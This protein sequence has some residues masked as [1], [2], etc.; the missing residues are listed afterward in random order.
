MPLRFT[1]TDLQEFDG[2]YLTRFAANIGDANAGYQLKFYKGAAGNN[3]IYSQILTDI[4]ANSWNTFEL[5]MPVEIDADHDLFIAIQVTNANNNIPTIGLDSG[6]AVVGKGD[7]VSFD[8]TNWYNLASHGI[9]RNFS[10]HV[11][12]DISAGGKA[13]AQGQWLEEPTYTEPTGEIKI[14]PVLAYGEAFNSTRDL[15]G[16]NVYRNNTKI[17]TSLV[18]GKAYT[19]INVSSGAYTYHVTTVFNG[20][21]SAPSVPV[22]VSLG[23]I[24]QSYPLTAGWNSISSHLIPAFADMN[25]IFAPIDDKVI[26]VNGIAGY[27]YPEYG[28]NTLGN[29]NVKNGYMIKVSNNCQLP[30]NGF[31][32]SSMSIALVK[33]WNLISVLSACEVNTAQLFNNIITKLII[34]KEAAGTGVYWPEHSI[35]TMPVLKPGKSYFIKMSASRNLVFPGCKE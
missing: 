10:M 3:L 30:F 26:M 11:Y 7:L 14:N 25:I 18:T 27:Y 24:Q 17:N 33:G 1:P 21:E 20:D 35:N 22:N 12:A 19:D 16:Y 34:V 28:I 29:W 9:D 13:M 23:A 2:L 31:T 8:G 6:P 32:N 5:S 4:V 15:I